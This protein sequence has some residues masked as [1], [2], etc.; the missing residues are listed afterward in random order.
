V[1]RLLPAASAGALGALLAVACTT[2]LELGER[3]Y[4]EGDRLA[5]LQIWRSVPEDSSEHASARRRIAEV[6]PEFE[7]LVVRYKQRARYFEQRDR[8]AESILSYRLA[9]ELQPGDV[10]TLDRVQ[11]LA[12]VLATRKHELRAEYAG[13]VASGDLAGARESLGRLRTL[14]PLDPELETGSRQLAA[15]LRAETLRLGQAGRSAFGAGNHAAAERAFRGV[16][17]LDPEDESARGYLS[18]IATIRGMGSRGGEAPAAFDPAAFA[19][20]AEIRAEGFHQNSL[21]AEREGDLYAAIRQ[22]LRA[23]RVGP[24]HAAARE[25]LANLRR[26]LAPDLE[27]LIEAGRT[28]F[29]NEDLQT[30]LESW[31]QALLVDPENERTRAYVARA[32]RQL[33][34]LERLRAEPAEAGNEGQ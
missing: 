19:T 32:E 12:R 13:A 25:H 7:R 10:A 33:Q 17:A 30:A 22:E 20:E 23:L 31:R 16:L 27:R 15:A 29:G 28:A 14:D 9:L 5:A 6:E 18:Y 26:R 1:S 21:A 3:H 24:D 2:P 11:G 4:R 8:L 34:N